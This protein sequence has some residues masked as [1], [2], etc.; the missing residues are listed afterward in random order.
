MKFNND[1]FSKL[2]HSPE[3]TAL[4]VSIAERGAAIARSTAPVDT[5]D[6]RDGI[7]VEVVRANRRNVAVI[8]SDDE[9]TM[10]IESETGNLARALGALKSGG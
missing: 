10:W 3:V 9:K 7:H 2:G 5:G 6:Y 4:C 1:F 8:K